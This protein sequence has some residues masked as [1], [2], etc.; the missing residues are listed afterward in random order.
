MVS[1]VA[2]VPRSGHDARTDWVVVEEG[3][4]ALVVELDD[5]VLAKAAEK[6]IDDHSMCCRAVVLQALVPAS[7]NKMSG[8]T[9]AEESPAVLGKAHKRN[10]VLQEHEIVA[11]ADSEFESVVQAGTA[12]F[13]SVGATEDRPES[14]RTAAEGSHYTVDAVQACDLGRKY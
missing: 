4:V 2:A 8:Q 10:G 9:L 14:W 11:V 3:L 1:E 7:H 13:A 5:I 6:C 12:G